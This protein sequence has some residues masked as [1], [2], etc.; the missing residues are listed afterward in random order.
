V[1][2]LPLAPH[3]LMRLRQQGYRL[4]SAVAALLAT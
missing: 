3:L 1:N 2:V 4:V